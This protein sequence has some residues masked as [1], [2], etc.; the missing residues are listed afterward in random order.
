[1][2]C[3]VIRVCFTDD[4]EDTLSS[5]AK[6][7]WVGNPVSEALVEGPGNKG[8]CQFCNTPE[9]PV[10]VNTAGEPMI[11]GSGESMTDVGAIRGVPL[12]LA[13]RCHVMA[14][15]VLLY[16]ARKVT[17]ARCMAGFMFYWGDVSQ[18]EWELQVARCP[19]AGLRWTFNLEVQLSGLSKEVLRTGEVTAA[20]T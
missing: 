18:V 7:F 13:H 16:R 11:G 17:S 19:C 8:F 14:L 4:H 3:P 1:M 9:V 10:I 15:A 20:H 6:L 12:E 2:G 5:P